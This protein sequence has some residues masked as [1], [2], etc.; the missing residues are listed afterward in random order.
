MGRLD[1]PLYGGRT[2]TVKV[3][4]CLRYL[5][6]VFFVI[7]NTLS[8][9]AKAQSIVEDELRLSKLTLTAFECSML[10]DDSK[11]ARK[12]FDIGFDAGRQFLEN[13][14]ELTNDERTE[15]SGQMD[16]LWWGVWDGKSK[17][18]VGQSMKPL[19]TFLGHSLWGP[20]IDF[21]LGRVFSNRA[22]WV[23]KI[24]GGDDAN[25]QTRNLN[26]SS[27]YREKNCFLIR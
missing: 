20:T 25:E 19:P 24:E 4:H 21:I 14:S 23:Y 13:I 22:E 5:P 9:G 3:L 26:K 1:C 27:M 11:D 8:E 10:T 6:I 16:L 2:V 15:V 17:S 7:T 18:I 12:L